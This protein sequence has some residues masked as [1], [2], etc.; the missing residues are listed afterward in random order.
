MTS[1]PP[2]ATDSVGTHRPPGVVHPPSAPPPTGNQLSRAFLNPYMQLGVGAVLVT[3]SELLLRLGARNVTPAGGAAG[4]FGVAAL[5][6]GWTWAGIVCYVLSFASWLYVLRFVPLGM[7]FALI[8]VVH[9]LIPI[10]AWLL[11]GEAV[12]AQRWAGVGL[13]V[14]GILLVAKPAAR[15]ESK[16]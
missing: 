4:L 16:L 8:N 15:A 7:A 2:A 9:V 11:L 10:G 5:A 12:S 1:A 14:A 6:S 3:A 13:V